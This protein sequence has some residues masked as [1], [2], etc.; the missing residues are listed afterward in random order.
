MHFIPATEIESK[1]CQFGS[2]FKD[3]K[4]TSIQKSKECDKP[5]GEQDLFESDGES[6]HFEPPIPIEKFKLLK[7]QFVPKYLMISYECVGK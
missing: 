4:L 5:D 7:F 2:R 6:Y 1:A 3:V